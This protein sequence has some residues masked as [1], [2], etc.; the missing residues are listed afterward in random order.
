MNHRALV[1]LGH[2]EYWSSD[3]RR[4][5]LAARKHGINLAFLG[6]NDVYRHIRLAASPL[7]KDRREI[8][9]K[10]ASE[11]PLY[12]IDNAEVTSQWREPPVPR[13]ESLLLGALYQCNPV[14]A[15]MVI[16][17]ASSWVFDGTGLGN[18][19]RLPG[20]IQLEYDRVDGHLPTPASVQILA[21]SP[22]TCRG[23]SDFSDL[24]YYTTRSG[25]GVIDIASQ[26]WVKLLTCQPPQQTTSCNQRAVRITANILRMFALG[27]AG[28]D[29]PSK[30]N[31]AAFGIQLEHPV[32]V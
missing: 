6:A 27:P 13:P 3:M 5:A 23:R 26:G 15:D 11:D 29:H 8:D 12:G 31:L 32:H 25:G 17:A 9:Y 18:G 20:A 10:V 24:T 30:P 22:L 7:G 21:H 4:G 2:D 14:Q 16:S 1:S 19:D 28:V